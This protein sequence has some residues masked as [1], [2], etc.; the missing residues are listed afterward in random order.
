MTKSLT[1]IQTEVRELSGQVKKISA[2]LE[3]LFSDIDA[4][5]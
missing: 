4:L 3:R 5:T 2:A 1:D